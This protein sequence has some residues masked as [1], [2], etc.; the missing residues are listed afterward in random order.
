MKDAGSSVVRFRRRVQGT[1]RALKKVTPEA[2]KVAA[3]VGR[4]G[5]ASKKSFTTLGLMFDRLKLIAATGV[6]FGAVFK[7]GQLFR[8]IEMFNRALRNSQA[9]MT[10]LN[11]GIRQQ[12]RQTALDVAKATVFSAEE[13][14]KAFFFLTS[15]GLNAQQAIRSLPAVANFAQAGMFDLSTATELLTDA[16]SALG[17]KVKDVEQNYKNMLKVSDALVKANQI[18]DATVEEFAEALTNRAAAAMKIFNIEL[19]DGIALLA[20]YADQ[21]LKAQIGGR[22]FDILLRDLTVKAIENRAAF[23]AAGIAVFTLGGKLRSPIAI[24]RDLEESF[25]GLSAEQIKTRQMTLQFQQRSLVFQT[26]LLGTSEA[27][28]EYS[29]TIKEAGGTSEEVARRQMTPFQKA[30]QRL[31]ASILDSAGALKKVIEGFASSIEVINDALALLDTLERRRVSRGGGPTFAQNAITVIRATASGLNEQI[32]AT[33][34]ALKRAHTIMGPP[35]PGSPRGTNVLLSRPRTTSRRDAFRAAQ[36]D[37]ER[38]QIVQNIKEDLQARADAAKRV[39]QSMRTAQRFFDDTRTSAEKFV[40]VLEDI[41][42]V[43]SDIDFTEFGGVKTLQKQLAAARST[44]LRSLGVQEDDAAETLLKRQKSLSE[45]VRIGK[46]G[47]DEADKFR[48]QLTEKFLEQM[49][50]TR[51]PGGGFRFGP[52]LKKPKAVKFPERGLVSATQAG[53]MAGA[54]VLSEAS[55]AQAKELKEMEKQTKLLEQ[56]LRE[57]RGGGM[58]Q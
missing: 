3:A 33:E 35:A 39:E 55:T 47:V 50:G 58:R 12:M 38:K 56:L 11:E 34:E 32:K 54:R 16:Q 30:W 4:V 8:D 1:T 42:R 14:A 27:M 31:S 7:F 57:Q 21:G 48:R 23:E 9:I 10:G 52:K 25:K 20:A 49:G 2:N 36:L 22:A 44:F 13:A 6:V 17:L 26:V 41:K 40:S 43:A 15:A 24:L 45:A 29:A 19:H 46:L 51:M 5:K 53:G 28:R 37:K 18:A